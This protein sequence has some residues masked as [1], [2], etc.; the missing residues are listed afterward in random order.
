MLAQWLLAVTQQHRVVQFGY[1]RGQLLELNLLASYF[2]TD[3]YLSGQS[4]DVLLDEDPI[5]DAPVPWR[6]IRNIIRDSQARAN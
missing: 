6:D 4:N 3:Y 1:P 5:L 2:Q